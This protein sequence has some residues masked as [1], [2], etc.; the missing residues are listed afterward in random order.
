[1]Y[2][3]PILTVKYLD[4]NPFGIVF[5]PI[6]FLSVRPCVEYS[7]NT[8]VS[9]FLNTI[10]NSP[11]GARLSRYNV[12]S[13]ARLTVWRWFDNLGGPLVRFSRC[14]ETLS[15]TL[16]TPPSCRASSTNYPTSR[17][18]SLRRSQ[19]QIRFALYIYSTFVHSLRL[20]CIVIEKRL[21]VFLVGYCHVLVVYET[22]TKVNL[23]QGTKP[24][25]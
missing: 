1:M 4:Q 17:V 12:F 18:R 15:R 11:W 10:T 21:T 23:K 25:V 8:D 20:F 22:H 2:I 19:G 14:G 16:E 24:T 7:S 3:G 9:E 6:S 13:R 5:S